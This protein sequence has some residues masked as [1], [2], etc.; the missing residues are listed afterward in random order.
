M[1]EENKSIKGVSEYLIKINQIDDYLKNTKKSSSRLS[2]FRGQGEN[3]PSI[4]PGIYRNEKFI[5]KEGS[6]FNSF[7]RMDP[8]LFSICNNN[9]DRLALMQHHQLPTRLL[10]LTTNPLI[11]LYFAV[12]DEDD[13]K[14]GVVY[15]FVKRYQVEDKMESKLSNYTKVLIEMNTSVVREKVGIEL[16][17]SSDT[18]E[19]MSSLVSLSDSDRKD[20]L[21]DLEV[22]GE[23]IVEDSYQDSNSVE[24]IEKWMEVYNNLI[25]LSDE[26]N[27]NKDLE[28]KLMKSAYD[29][30]N[31]ASDTKRLYHEIKSD[32]G[33][34]DMVINPFD[35]L[36]PKIVKPRVIDKR[37]QNQSGVL[38]FVPF[39]QNYYKNKQGMT[40]PS[41]LEVYQKQVDN[42]IGLLQYHDK[43][44]ER[45]SLTIDKQ[46]KKKIKY[47][48]YK[49]G[50]GPNFIY[51]GA[52]R[53]AEEIEME[54]N[55]ES[56]YI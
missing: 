52:T 1:S 13:S 37:I 17:T 11:A 54:L 26:S 30:F 32:I 40:E 42:L 12:E 3:H 8:N 46:S 33:A 49:L 15:P 24:R 5:K 45:E 2:Y 56:D 38:L 6:L 31:R 23:S 18:I 25:V 19:I 7:L 39:I 48:L 10:D 36:L 14:D 51:P 20:F 28:S 4:I 50:I 53:V 41:S 21:D 34:F 47:E 22:F 16:S 43:Q 9:F 55:T 35:I 29:E 44:G 27:G